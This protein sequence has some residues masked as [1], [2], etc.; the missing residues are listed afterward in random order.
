MCYPAT[1]PACDP[2]DDVIAIG[3]SFAA[4]AAM[5]APANR[6]H[7]DVGAA[8]ATAAAPAHRSGSRP[9]YY[10]FP[11]PLIRCTRPGTIRTIEFE[12]FRRIASLWRVRPPMRC[13]R[14]RGM[15]IDS[16]PMPDTSREHERLDVDRIL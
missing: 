9:N 2:C 4:A 15:L 16:R 8:A 7:F 14:A 1:I 5:P 13:D 11:Q 12:D 3:A 10:G 6:G